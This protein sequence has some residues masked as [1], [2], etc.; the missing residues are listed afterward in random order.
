MAKRKAR[1]YK[2]ETP[3]PRPKKQTL[4]SLRDEI[5]RLHVQLAGCGTAA[6]GYATRKRGKFQVKRTAWGW[7]PALED[8]MK[9]YEKFRAA[10]RIVEIAEFIVGENNGIRGVTALARDRLA[11]LKAHIEKYNKLTG[12]DKLREL[13]AETEADVQRV[14]VF[15]SLKAVAEPRAPSK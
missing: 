15:D 10:D 12:K 13:L 5:E 1:E 4:T 8:V 14:K 6:M 11:A 9:L 2:G 7:S 3:K